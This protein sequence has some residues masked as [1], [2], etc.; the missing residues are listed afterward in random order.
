MQFHIA[1]RIDHVALELTGPI[2]LSVLLG[3]I[4]K[5]GDLMI[6]SRGLTLVRE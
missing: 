6:E 3:L 5:L 1:R 4:E 2:D